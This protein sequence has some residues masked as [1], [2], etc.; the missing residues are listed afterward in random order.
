MILSVYTDS[1]QIKFNTEPLFLMFKVVI[2]YLC[3]NVNFASKQLLYVIMLHRLLLFQLSICIYSRAFYTVV[4]VTYRPIRPGVL[5]LHCIYV[6]F[7]Y[8]NTCHYNKRLLLLLLLLLYIDRLCKIFDY[9]TSAC[10]QF[11]VNFP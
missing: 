10:V 3:L 2:C 9:V 4:K 11:T 8:E 1:I 6:I 7:M 5:Y